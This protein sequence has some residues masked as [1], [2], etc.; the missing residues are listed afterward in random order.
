V[1]V[2]NLTGAMLERW[3]GKLASLV[4]PGGAA[5]VSGFMES[6]TGVLPALTPFLTLHTVNQEDEWMCAV[7][8]RT[9]HAPLEVVP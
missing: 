7:L 6:E 8:G 1:V 9:R 2:A 4:L 5:I 3:G